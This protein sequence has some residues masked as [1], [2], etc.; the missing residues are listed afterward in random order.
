VRLPVLAVFVALFGAIARIAYALIIHHPRHHATSDAYEYIALAHRFLDSPQTQTLSDTIWP[1]G[2]SAVWALLF[3]VDGSL[4]VLAIANVVA[5]MAVVVLIASSAHLAAGTRAGWW[6]LIFASLHFGLIHYAGFTLAEQFFQLTATF[7]VWASV[8]S[9]RLLPLAS[10]RARYWKLLSGV[11]TGLAWGLAALFRPNALPVMLMASGLLALHW[12]RTRERAAI[13]LVAGVAL[14][15]LLVLVPASDRCTR[16]AGGNFCLVSN[17]IAMN[18]ALGQ[19]GAVYGLDFRDPKTPEN[20]TSWV[21]PALLH[22]GYKGLG[23]LPATI[24]DTRG[25]LRWYGNRFL[26]SPGVFVGRALGNGL[27]LF[28]IDYWPDNYDALGTRTATILK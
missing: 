3:S 8:L 5:S 2:T 19:A 14:G 12:I 4:S 18:M 27:D 15:L 17:N 13:P 7:A 21:P 16:N 24:Y 28:G 20:A 23:K 22:H 6:A 10:G 11:A 1:P 26:E 9:L 25:L